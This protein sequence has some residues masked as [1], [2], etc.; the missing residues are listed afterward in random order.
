MKRPM[1]YNFVNTLELQVLDIFVGTNIN[2][3]NRKASPAYIFKRIALI[4]DTISVKLNTR[5]IEHNFPKCLKNFIWK[6][7][8]PL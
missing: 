5:D 2:F 6:E 1:Q 4:N 7:D 3:I 8:A